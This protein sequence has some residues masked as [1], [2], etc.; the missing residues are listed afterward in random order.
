[1]RLTQG[2]H[3][4]RLLCPDRTATVYGDRRRSWTEL[5]DRISR[6]AGG[7][8][9][10]GARAGDRIGIIAL[11][12]DQMIEA[13]YAILWAG[14]VAVPFNTRWADAEVDHAL[15]DSRPRIVLVDNGFAEVH[16]RLSA[17]GVTIIGL[18]GSAGPESFEAL[19]GSNAPCPDQ[20]RSGDEL[21]IIFYT[22]G[23]TGRSKGVML[24]HANLLI[25]FAFYSMVAPHPP[26]T[27]FLHTPPLFHLGDAVML[28][29][30]TNIGATH[31][32]LP[33][34]DPDAVIDAV[35]RHGANALFLVPT[36]IGML[37]E[38]LRTRPADMSG[39]TRLNY[40]AAPIS[41]SLLERAM[42][43]LP[44]AAFV[45]AY[46]QTELSPFATVLDHEDHLGDRL[47][48]AGRPIPSVDLRIV[49]AELREVPRGAPGEIVVRG[50]GVMLGYWNLLEQ[51][52]RTIVD[53]WLRTGDA[54]YM[55]DNGY[56]FLVDRVKDM[57]VSGGENIYSAEVERALSSHPDVLQCAVIG[58]PD[59]KWGE[60]VHAILH[61]RPGSTACAADL[62]AHCEPLIAN[63]KRPK[64]LDL[65]TEPLPLSGVG[66]VMKAEL[67]KP[68][69][70]GRARAIA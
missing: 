24:S 41:R 5:A 2:L 68:F 33:G 27:M 34:F 49:D 31:V 43:A 51:T 62:I 55:D 37:C 60:R 47:N 52:E 25:N 18:A 35:E 36:M 67:R 23:T 70:E 45:Q 63:Y 26:G 61:V 39:V 30:L 21:A 44:N 42:A 65:R 16:A 10:K 53:G 57:I 9:A 59:D 19:I 32:V 48:S 7:L 6:L 29:G 50:P 15:D 40:G 1:M 56:L 46:G 54:G 3:R 69:W 28:F 14:C 4:N 11:N 8:H 12:S 13:Y 64:S 17:R 66:K 20:C 22:G 38:A 58:V